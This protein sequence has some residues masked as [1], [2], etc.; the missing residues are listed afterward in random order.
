MDSGYWVTRSTHKGGVYLQV[1]G[2]ARFCTVGWHFFYV[3]ENTI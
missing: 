2:L 3:N 1:G